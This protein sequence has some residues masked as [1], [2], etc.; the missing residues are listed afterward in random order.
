M[1]STPHQL[2]TIMVLNSMVFLL[3]PFDA[4]TQIPISDG[5]SIRVS[6]TVVDSESISLDIITLQNMTIK[7]DDVVEGQN[8]IYVSPITGVNAG[9]MLLKGNPNAGVNIHYQPEEFIY[10]K[11]DDDYLTIKYVMSGYEER[12][13]KASTLLETADVFVKLSD[14]GEYYLW[15]GGLIDISNATGGRFSGEFVFEISYL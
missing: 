6:A 8:A 1:L 13:Q 5:V 9:L 12:I 14:V 10:S 11:S 4:C 2:L 7:P 15:V 3:N